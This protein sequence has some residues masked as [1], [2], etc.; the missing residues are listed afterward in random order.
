MIC[1]PAMLGIQADSDPIRPH[2]LTQSFRGEFQVRQGDWKYLDH[3]GSGGNGYEKGILKAYSLPELAPNATGQLYNLKSDPGE[4]T[5][6]FFKE[7]AKRIEMQRLLKQLTT[8]GRS[9]PKQ[10]IPLKY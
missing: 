5:N 8:S 3:M 10:R 6:L 2:M 1:F 4:T 7:E 9:A